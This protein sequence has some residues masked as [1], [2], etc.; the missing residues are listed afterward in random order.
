MSFFYALNFDVV[1]FLCNFVANNK[2]PLIA[3]NKYQYTL[4]MKTDKYKLLAALVRSFFESFSSGIIDNCH[5]EKAEDRNSAQT[6]KKLM[7]EHY[8]HIAPV[9]FDTLFFPLAAMNFE[10]A[11]IER[12]VREAQQ[13]GDDMMALVKTACA[14]DAM[15]EAMVAEYKRNFSNLLAGRYATTADHLISYTRG[16]GADAEDID[17]DRAIELTVRVVMYAYAR[18]LR[19]G[20]EGRKAVRQASLFRLLIDAM[21]VLLLDEAV[22]FEDDDEL[23]AMFLKV[24]LNEHNFTVMTS[25]MDRTFDELVRKEGITQ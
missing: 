11:D 20:T 1:C 10:Y 3:T 4:L 18:G 22:Q 25:E 21:N 2:Q 7:L 17:T 6:V 12:V 5:I 19:R 23:A 8:E 14:S 16:D 15:Y 9:F 13:R 24:C